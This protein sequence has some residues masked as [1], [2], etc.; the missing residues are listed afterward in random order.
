[1]TEDEAITLM[2]SGKDLDKAQ[3]AEILGH[4]DHCFI[5]PPTVV[6]LAKPFG[7]EPKI[8]YKVVNREDPKGLDVPGVPDGS[9]VKGLAAD[10]LAV[11]ICRHLGLAHDTLCGR[12][13]QLRHC[14]EV[15]QKSLMVQDLRALESSGSSLPDLP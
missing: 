1:M 15:I 9:S 5:D 13:S 2:E 11:Q 10:W 6:R 8:G 7:F 4:L 12:G 3:A 14:V